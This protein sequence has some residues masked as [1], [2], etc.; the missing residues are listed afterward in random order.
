MIDILGLMFFAGY[1]GFFIGS[2]LTK[3]PS[4][5][6]MLNRIVMNAANEKIA[7]YMRKRLEAEI[8]QKANNLAV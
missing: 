4:E 6:E 5:E 1:I 2:T 7:K 3:S 8:E